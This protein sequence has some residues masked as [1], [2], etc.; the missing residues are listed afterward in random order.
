VF[1]V[2]KRVKAGWSNS[3][4]ENQNAGRQMLGE[5]TEVFSENDRI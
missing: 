1:V 5:A 3:G 2:E 4:D